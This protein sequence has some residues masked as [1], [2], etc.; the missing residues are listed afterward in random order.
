MGNWGDKCSRELRVT[1]VIRIFFLLK[2]CIINNT[3]NLHDDSVG[4]IDVK[5]VEIYIL[6]EAKK[7]HYITQ[8]HNRKLKS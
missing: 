6:H 4:P 2:K 3:Y 7:F 1:I 5:Y 8:K